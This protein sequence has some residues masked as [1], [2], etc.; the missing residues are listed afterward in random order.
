MS[1]RSFKS[2]YRMLFCGSSGRSLTE[3]KIQD[4]IIGI[5]LDNASNND[6]LVNE[7]SAIVPRFR[8]SKTHVRCFTHILNLVVKAVLSQFCKKIKSTSDI[9]EYITLEEGFADDEEPEEPANKE[10]ELAAVDKSD[11]Q[12]IEDIDS[13]PSLSVCVL[14]LTTEEEKLD[15]FAIHKLR[16]LGI[17]I[18]NSPTIKAD[19]AS[20]CARVNIKPRLMIKNLH[21]A[22]NLLVV[23]EEYNKPQSVFLVMTHKISQSETP[24]FHE[25]I[26]IFDIITTALDEFIDNAMREE[27][28]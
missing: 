7:L 12:M 4:K 6:T 21:D 24:L 13:E 11:E 23:K 16:V 15:Q 1:R 9:H 20:C 5:V 19:L 25:F 22:L 26:P 17:K 2:S 10:D 28:T 18:V 8:G 3:Y 27:T 14:P